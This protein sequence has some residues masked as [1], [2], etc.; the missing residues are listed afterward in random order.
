[1][2]R[3]DKQPSVDDLLAASGGR[4]ADLAP[5]TERSLNERDAQTAIEA[6]DL[7]FQRLVVPLCP[8]SGLGLLAARHGGGGRAMLWHLMRNWPRVVRRAGA[9]ALTVMLL[10][11]LVFAPVAA[12]GEPLPAFDG[13]FT[14]EADVT[15]AA[16]ELIWTVPESGVRWN[17]EAHEPDETVRLELHD[18]DGQ[19]LDKA[20]GPGRAALL[21]LELDAGDYRIVLQKGQGESDVVALSAAEEPETFDPEPNDTP[22]TAVPVED[23]GAI[24]GRLARTPGDIDHFDLVVTAGDASLRDVELSWPGEL[25]REL[26]LLDDDGRAR[27]CR[28]GAEG[29]TLTDLALEPGR[30][31]FAVSG[32][33][34]EAAPYRF[35]ATVTRE[36]AP[37][38][39]AEPNDDYT[40]ADTFTVEGGVAGRSD[41][42]ERDHH[43]V[44]IEGEPQLWRIEAT[45]DQVADLTYVRGT[46]EIG[47]S[48]SDCT[49]EPAVLDDLILAPGTHQFLVR[50]CGGE[51]RL[52]LT[53][54]GQRDPEGEQEPNSDDVRAESYGIG[55]RRVGRLTTSDD[56][57]LFRFT[58]P[59]AAGI[60][61][62][63]DQ[64]AGALTRVGLT[65]GG[66]EKFRRT[67]AEPGSTLDIDLW[68]DAGDYLL[69][70][71]PN[72]PSEGHYSLTTELLA[73]ADV[74]TDAEPNEAYG[75]AREVPATLTW[76]GHSDAVDRDIDGY[77]LPP[78][79]EP[80]PVRIRV[81]GEGPVLRLWSDVLEHV[82][83]TL[84]EEEEGV[85]V[86]T[87]APTDVP[88][89][90]DLYA[91][92]DYEVS[93]EAP[94][95]EAASEPAELSV[96]LDV[97]LATDAVAAYWPEGQRVPAAITATN[98]GTEP[99]E[100]SLETATS[101]YAWEL[102][103][104]ADSVSLPAGASQAIEAS[105]EIDADVWADAPVRM[106][107]TLTAPDG[108]TITTSATADGDR[109]TEAV[110]SH[111]AWPLPD[112]LVGGLNVA[113]AALGGEPTDAS[114]PWPE[115]L[116]YDGVTPAGVGFRTSRGVPLEV[117]VDLA[118]EAPI[119]IAGTILNPLANGV[120]E[121]EAVRDFELLLSS[122]G[123][124][125]TSAL[126][127]ELTRLPVEQAFVL[128]QPMP[129]THAMLRIHSVHGAQVGTISSL[130][131]WKVV[132]EPGAIPDDMS[133]NIAEPVRGGH[134][135]RIRPF[136]T[137]P[138]DWL[139]PLDEALSIKPR[140]VDRSDGLREIVI[141]FHEGRTAQ[142]TEL[143][144]QDP[145]LTEEGRRAESVYLDVSTEGPLGPW[146][147]ITE[148]DLTRAADGSVAPLVLDEPVWARYVRLIG[149]LPPE[150]V[151]H[152]EY[153]G[154]I[155]VHE[156]PTDDEYRSILAEWGYTSD[157]GPYEL[158]VPPRITAAAL[159]PDAGDS[160]SEA[161]PLERGVLR[162]DRAEILDDDDWYR[163][164]VPDG[165][166]T[167]TLEVDGLPTVGVDLIVQD[168]A[169]EALDL[170]TVSLVGG[171]TRYAAAVDPG[172]Y[173]VRVQQV[174]FNVV[175][176][177][178]TSG[179]MGPFLDYVLEGMRVFASDVQPGREMAMIVP[180]D[181]A[182]LLREWTDQPL[183][184]A[185]AV[186]GFVP[187]GESSNVERG[188][189]RGALE[190][191][192]QEGVRAILVIGDAET[193]TLHEAPMVWSAF[194]KVRPIVYTVHVGAN[195]FPVQ[196]RN[197][198]RPWA[199]S[200]GGVY[201]YPTTHAE[202]ER[203]FERMS[204]RLRRPS[205]YTIEAAA[206]FI[207][208]T[209]AELRV[210]APDG[211]AAALAPGVG[212]GL[213]LDTSGSMRSKLDGKQRIAIAKASLLQLVRGGLSEGVPVAIR[214][215][216]G[217]GKSKAAR[218]ETTL[219]LPLGPLDAAKASK[220]VKSLK[221]I[222]K[223]K[224]PIADG[225]REMATDLRSVEGSKTIVLVT[226][227]D[228]TC[229]GDPEAVIAEL[230]EQG[231]EVNLNIVGFAL[232]D[233]VLKAQ[234]A[235]WAEAGGGSYFDAS[236][237][238]ELASAIATAVSAPWRVF[239]LEGEEPLASSTVGGDGVVLAPGTY[240][241]EVLSD[242]TIEFDAVELSAG[243]IVT[244]RL[245]EPE[246]AGE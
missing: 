82:R 26:C 137:G 198:M 30:H 106:S 134:V 93:L 56:R 168:A 221:A 44:T 162:T 224:T 55:E 113:A 39:E 212:V 171:G 188:L 24:S 58:L 84:I 131:E 5:A 75:Y 107:V 112:A 184:L 123:E 152:I 244:L 145:E 18:A 217:G 96:E 149:D 239:E 17:I 165:A 2:V 124:N 139:L 192:S 52:V 237:A 127:G 7:L 129:A 48:A 170:R 19:P 164:T 72:A 63:L 195:H 76:T 101:H 61:L 231:I 201:T 178:D 86:A 108:A 79:S 225:I 114:D 21:D 32:P 14:T 179:S 176:T 241:V 88:L 45:G 190:L 31:V 67:I 3:D 203:S 105:L 85:F 64:P 126:R 98:T 57:D 227:G 175:F 23:D 28:K 87:D 220:L 47:R 104:E 25:N 80:G 83:L 111:L 8:V 10:A 27:Q 20:S 122:D 202:T 172:E 91:D 233:E 183:L 125:W 167:L 43:A 196:T 245:P 4:V 148:W 144:W 42:R 211:Q 71:D 142:I 117:M 100:L 242:P 200:N 40:V 185:A 209:P 191:Q 163:V 141:G 158:L 155:E 222:K 177:F 92:G 140:L 210:S 219:S 50:G 204:T 36:R 157:R 110:G 235:A 33:T 169:G 41:D 138:G 38:F 151:D 81:I 95:W 193:G 70:L 46:A 146:Q 229:G 223:T 156:R 109:D 174:P 78:L 166:N 13:A 49:G 97:E 69:S 197:L 103:A 236:G 228:E 68:L 238:G 136:I 60:R 51:Y 130:G 182:P 1:M 243:G 90:L 226:D 205:L 99:L 173:F 9:A 215:F 62:R 153:P 128:E 206:P 94:G 154:R 218:C 89:Y 77:W 230:R 180:F 12:Q 160:A 121:H 232:D 6:T 37:D 118:G 133:L 53:P 207:D 208:R 143:T 161:T 132:A 199:A 102:V 181:R 246:P 116:L 214:T 65:S 54:L 15:D 187:E 73:P 66:T 22:L 35:S 135:A 234:M 186:N 213:I 189:Q 120:T 194:E 240:R 29:V 147:R 150:D 115:V 74:A 34:D 59:V 16:Y 119:P 11:V 159:E 216:G